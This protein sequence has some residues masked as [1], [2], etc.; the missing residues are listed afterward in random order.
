MNNT[1]L[2]SACC[3]HASCSG[4]HSFS[5]SNGSTDA[6]PNIYRLPRTVVPSHYDMTI[7][8]DG[9]SRLFHGE[10]SITVDVLKA[11]STIKLNAKNLVVSSAIARHASGTTLVAVVTDDADKEMV[12]LTFDGKLA[13]STWVLEL[14][15]AGQHGN[16]SQGFF[17]TTWSDSEKVEHTMLCTQFESADARSA[18][19]CFDEPDFKAVFKVRLVVANELTALSNGDIV[20]VTPSA[21]NPGKKVVEFEPT[22][23]MSTYVVCF[24]VG[25]LAHSE[26]FYVNGKRLQIWCIPGKENE[27]RFAMEASAF[28]LDY[29]EKY[30]EI[31]YPFGSK[32]DL[33]AVPDFAWG[34]MENVGLV[35]FQPRLLLVDENRPGN[36]EHVCQIIM[37]ELAHQW[38]GDLVTMRWWNGLWLN[39]SFATF[40]Q[41]KAADAFNSA[42]RCWDSF[43]HKRNLAYWT[44][45][46]RSSHPIEET[47]ERGGDAIFLVD[48]ISYEKGCSVLYQTEHLLSAEVL[49]QGISLYLKKHAFGNTES[50]DLWN[51]LEEACKANS[52]DLPIRSIM[53]AW[54]FQVG[55]PEVIVTKG[56]RPGEIVLTQRPFLLLERGRKARK[57]WPIPIVMKVTDGAGAVKRDTF[58]LNGRTRR[59]QVGE[60][61]QVKVNA[62]GSGFYRVRYAPELLKLLTDKIDTMGGIELLNLIAD[63]RAMF[64]ACLMDAPAYIEFLF[65]VARRDDHFTW[66]QALEGFDCVSRLCDEKDRALLT[67][68]IAGRLREMAEEKSWNVSLKSEAPLAIMA[69]FKPYHLNLTPLVQKLSRVFLRAWVKDPASVEPL[70]AAQAAMV[71]YFGSVKIPAEFSELQRQAMYSTPLELQRYISEL[72]ERNATTASAPDFFDVLAGI[73]THQGRSPESVVAR[74]VEEWPASVSGD[75]PAIQVI[76]SVQYGGLTDIDEARLETQL[77][78]CFKKHPY[79]QADPIVRR[80]MER[81]RAN[82][83]M[84]EKQGPAIKAVLKGM[85]KALRLSKPKRKIKLF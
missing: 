26:P 71:L 39:E 49:R 54:I 61:S 33:V 21:E 8:P 37:H 60:Y 27:T 63:A 77:K 15:F 19:P 5:N 20:S 3:H 13:A 1:K 11:T 73:I 59:L 53:E 76:H 65:T 57:L 9:Q 64:T 68:L 24:V 81:I 41:Y 80:T 55:H 69:D 4:G 85:V 36:K 70:K 78:R 7:S 12:E 29:F 82:V 18:F 75:T 46:V 56:K 17:A 30:F 2:A 10:V 16:N 74:F 38:F 40:M 66:H 43:G 23:K 45:S 47:V 34:G 25:E 72:V 51:S 62:G 50:F 31:P 58:V 35:V 22:L 67:R 6:A 79:R 28:G 42:W 84:R 44:D 83:V 14:K 52:L 32:I 48:P